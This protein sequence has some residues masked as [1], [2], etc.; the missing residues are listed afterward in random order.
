V[1]SSNLFGDVLS[2][3]GSCNCIINSYLAVGRSTSKTTGCV[4]IH[5]FGRVLA[6]LWTRCDPTGKPLGC[7]A[8]AWAMLVRSHLRLRR[9]QD[10]TKP[11]CDT[12]SSLGLPPIVEMQRKQQAQVTKKQHGQKIDEKHKMNGREGRRLFRCL[13]LRGGGVSMRGIKPG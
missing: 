4:A 10:L 9:R 3:D 13:I 5:S 6:R 7:W 11:I 1:A 12:A 2:D 8:S